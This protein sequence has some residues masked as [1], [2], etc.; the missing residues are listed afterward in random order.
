MS[1]VIAGGTGLLGSA[2]ADAL[3]RDGHTVLVLTRRPAH[4]HEIGWSPREGDGAWAS[5]VSDADAVVNLAGAS[6]GGGRWTSAR[7]EAIRESRMQATAALVRAIVAAPRPPSVFISASAVGFY[8]RRDDEPATEATP[9]GSDFLADVCRDWEAVASQASHSSRVVLLRS[10][11]VLARDGGALPQLALPFKLFAGGPAGSGRQFMSWIHVDDWVGM[12]KWA[13]ATT[14]VTGAL[15]VTAPTPVTNAEFARTLG[16][17]LGRPSWMR[18]PAFAL[19]L[20]LG[21]MADAL[22]LGGQRVL[23]DVAQRRGFVFRY[24]TLEAALRDIY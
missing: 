13:L 8:G 20:A 3:R 5:A 12:V 9:P 19:R 2:L 7:K 11:V 21:E 6:I 15:N 17:A 1:I 4:D 22:V 23:P 14:D 24:P 16:R 10:G 18:A